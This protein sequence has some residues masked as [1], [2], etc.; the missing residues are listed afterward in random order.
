MKCL[1]CGGDATYNRA[2][3][4]VNEDTIVGGFCQRCERERFGT[5][6]HRGLWDEVDG[7]IFCDG[8]GTFAL[9]VHEIDIRMKAGREHVEEGYGVS[10]LTPT[11]CTRHLRA[12]LGPDAWSTI[13]LRVKPRLNR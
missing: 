9:P 6:L 5:S 2:V 3:V 13:E 1:D 12:V 7:C 4:D 10:E 11:V 8:V